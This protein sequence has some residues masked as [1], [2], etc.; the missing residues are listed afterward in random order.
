MAYVALLL[1]TAVIFI[2]PQEWV[3][4]MLGMPV[5]DFVVGFAVLAWLAHLLA[6]D[7][8]LKDAPQN[9]LVLG[10]FAAVLMS[11]VRHTYLGALQEE[12]KTFGKVVLIYFLIAST[13]DST[14]RIKG[15][16]LI[17]VLGCLFMSGHGILQAHRGY[18]FGGV[19]RGAPFV[20]GDLVRV[21]AFGIFNDPNDLS[22]ML[23]AVMPFLLTT[24]LDR[25]RSPFA[26]VGSLA[27][28]LPMVYCVY[29][30]DSR[31]GWLA[32]AVMAMAFVF[33]HLRNKK[34]AVLLAVA[35]VP[36]VFAL[37]PSRVDTM[38]TDDDSVG[39][40]LAAWGYGNWM[41]KRWPLFG[42]GKGRFTEFSGDGKVAHNSFVHC[43]GELGLVGYFFWLGLVLASFK[44][45]WALS[46]A[47]PEDPED[48]PDGRALSRLGQAGVASMAGFMSA[49]F[50]LSRTYVIPLFILFALFAAM[51]TVY[52]Q[53]DREAPGL[54]DTAHWKYLLGAEIISIPGLWLT[55][56]IMNM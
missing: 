6:T 10:L 50:F 48:D 38:S 27:A 12:F 45:C 56:R 22:L 15:F 47:G 35:A 40:R 3:S 17:M 24:A 29:L 53:E 37:G 11:H 23:V 2:R 43:W 55:L 8:K 7:W 14:R 34:I 46:R 42:A 26:R 25:E 52:Q 31:G 9:L 39:G 49:S 21:R 4:W 36:L 54:A 20:R 41:L 33:V 18:G 5:L 44:D 28:V 1:Y 16:I 19:L 51:H 32:L 13:T 30:T